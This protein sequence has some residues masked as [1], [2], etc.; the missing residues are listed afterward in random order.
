MAM[1]T[2]KLVLVV[3]AV[4]LAVCAAALGMSQ[5]LK[6]ERTTTATIDRHVE[7]VIVH[8]NAGEVHLVG[9]DSNRVSVR[10][11][12]RWLWRRP[13]VHIRAQRAT[14]E[15]SGSCPDTSALN[16]CKADLHLAVP[17]D[18]DV[19]VVNDAGDVDVERLAG[20]LELNTDTGDVT[21]RDLNPVAVLAKTKEGD[22]DLAFTTQPVSVD[23]ASD[24]GDVRVS[25]PPGGEY[26]V[27]AATK[28]GD[29]NV[30]GV[31]RND[32]ALRS[33]SATADAGDV[34]VSGRGLDTS[35]A[36]P[37]AVPQA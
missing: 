17:F 2:P 19:T 33:I 25:V 24:A 7:R 18:A 35:V 5:A 12:L 21:G 34:T 30:Q 15:V 27:D 16:R 11:D 28:A 23:A 31:L 26:R 1:S 36:P 20:H 22:V 9:T 14:L 8:A 10:E 3:L 37:A 6:H 4:L 32:H 29:V 13:A